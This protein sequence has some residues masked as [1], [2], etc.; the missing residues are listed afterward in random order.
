MKKVIKSD[1]E[2]K[3]ILTPEQY[4]ILRK[5]GTEI[6]CSSTLLP[7]KGEGT[8]HCVGC[9][10]LLF[11]SKDKF[12]SGTGW[13]SFTKPASEESVIY[14]GNNFHMGVEVLCA[15]CEGHLGHVFNDGPKPIGKRYC[16]NG[17]ILKFKPKK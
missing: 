4:K 11:D 3:K 10:N 17:K 8:Y 5:S 15:R 12:E 1:S 16:I 14:K 2:W 6:A 7:N 9:G 13:P